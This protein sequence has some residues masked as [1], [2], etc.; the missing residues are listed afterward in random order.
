M[1]IEMGYQNPS[2]TG[3]SVE[4]GGLRRGKKQMVRAPGEKAPIIQVILLEGTF[5]L[6]IVY[7]RTYLKIRMV[8]VRLDGWFSG[9][10]MCHMRTGVWIPRIHQGRCGSSHL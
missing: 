5:L 9:Q 6:A 1:V 10:S 3:P 2:S 7:L 8:K 4:A